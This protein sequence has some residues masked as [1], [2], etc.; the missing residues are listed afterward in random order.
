ME[1]LPLTAHKLWPKL[2][3]LSQTGRDKDRTK[4]RCLRSQFQG[5]TYNNH[6]IAVVRQLEYVQE[7]TS[8]LLNI[9]K[10]LA[11]I[12]VP[13]MPN[14]SACIQAA[15]LKWMRAIGIV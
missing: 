14:E 2:K 5:L 4:I 11:K 1:S 15:K 6:W 12:T 10:L 13:L 7:M 8:S 3:L 9:V